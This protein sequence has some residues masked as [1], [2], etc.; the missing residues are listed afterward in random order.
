AQVLEQAGALPDLLV[1][2]VGGG[3]N[4]IGLFFA[5]LQDP[6]QMVGVEAGGRSSSPGEHASRFL[7]EAAGASVGVLHGT[8]TYLLQDEAGNVLPTHSVSAGLD[9]P[10]VGPEHALLR[11]QGRVRYA[12]ATDAEAL[13]AFHLLC[14][15]EG[16]IPALESAHAVAW[17]AREA[18]AWKGKLVLVNLSGRG[19]KDLESVEKAVSA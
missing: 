17:L 7:P 14:E 4:A 12:H 13:A 3:S 15:T 5:F 6:V 2:C 19:D 18:A 8:R 9:Y 10:A 1:A 11:D 16:V